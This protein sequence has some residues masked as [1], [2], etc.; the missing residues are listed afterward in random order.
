MTIVNAESCAAARLAAMSTLPESP[1]PFVSAAAAPASNV[2]VTGAAM[3]RLELRPDET[4]LEACLRAGVVTPFSCKGG[5][6]QTCLMRAVQG[7]PPARSQRGLPPELVA[8]GYFLPCVCVPTGPL[9]VAPP[10]ISDRR[11]ECRV[12]AWLPA[13]A[14]AEGAVLRLEPLAAVPASRGECFEIEAGAPEAC[15]AVAVGVPDE[16]F[17]LELRL[18]AVAAATLQASARAGVDAVLHVSRCEPDDP[19]CSPVTVAA[20]DRPDAGNVIGEPYDA[21]GYPQGFDLSQ[22]FVCVPAPPRDPALWAELDNGR[23]VRAILDEFY[24]RVFA[25]DRL[26]PYFHGTTAHHVAGKQYSFLHK[27]MTGADVYF[28]DNPRNAHHW[29]VID[30]DLFDHRQHLMET[31]Q[32]EYGLSEA[33]M[34][35]WACFEQ[36]F[37]PDIVKAAPEPRWRDGRWQ[38]MPHGFA[39]EILL[40]GSPCDHCGALIEPGTTVRYHQR[41]GTISCPACSRQPPSRTA[42]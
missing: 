19:R 26:R 11:Y 37:R 7:E 1:R 5:T 18:A 9:E 35:R 16:D 28:G 40:E 27:A 6:C 15:L 13:E 30:D 23:T 17:Y 4:L 14:M 31:V 33:Q 36:P 12:E 24:R 22:P 32:R 38:P 21:A 29:M 34:A 2:T 20:T 8:K 39:D 10:R 3:G 25:D 41:L 42:V